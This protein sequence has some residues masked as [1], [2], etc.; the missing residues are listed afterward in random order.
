MTILTNLQKVK[1]IAAG[2]ENIPDLT[3][4]S[5]VVINTLALVEKLVT[6][7]KFGTLTEEAQT[8][9]AAHLL[10]LAFTEAGGRGPLSSE[11]IGDITTSYTLPYLNQ[12]SVIASTQYGL[13]FIELRNSLIPKILVV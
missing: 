12:Q 1:A 2:D 4:A 7:G 13:Y 5:P 9:Y 3:E 8:Y 6:V 10:S 11:S